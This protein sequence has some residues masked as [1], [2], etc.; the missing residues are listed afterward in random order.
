MDSLS[1]PSYNTNSYP[2]RQPI[3]SHSTPSN[4]YFSSHQH[5]FSSTSQLTHPDLTSYTTYDTTY[6]N[7]AVAAAYQTTYPNP[8]H[9]N[10]TDNSFD[11]DFSRQ[12]GGFYRPNNEQQQQQINTDLSERKISSST[13]QLGRKRKLQDESMSTKEILSIYLI[14]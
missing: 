3:S 14:P 9:T 5:T 8:Y 10:P 2:F 11:I 12:F 4:V 1:Y 6:L 13:I 7:A